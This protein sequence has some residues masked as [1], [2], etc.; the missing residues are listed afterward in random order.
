GLPVDLSPLHG[1]NP[2]P[3]VDHEAPFNWVPVP[4]TLPTPP[5]LVVWEVGDN[6]DLNAYGF[7]RGELQGAIA[8]STLGWSSHSELASTRNTG[9][10]RPFL[11]ST[12]TTPTLVGMDGEEDDLDEEGFSRRDQRKAMADTVARPFYGTRTSTVVNGALSWEEWDMLEQ[13]EAVPPSP[14]KMVQPQS[15]TSMR[16]ETEIAVPCWP[17]SPLPPLPEAAP[18]KAKRLP[19]LRKI[20]KKIIPFNP[21]KNRSRAS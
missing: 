11:L 12:P 18:V 20:I 4:P 19:R 7:S 15:P 2:S 6:N 1:A 13:F 8:E 14:K 3:F 9:N 16:V 5:S 17:S 21:F 10:S